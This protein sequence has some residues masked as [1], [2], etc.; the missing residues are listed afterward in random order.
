MGQCYAPAVPSQPIPHP[1]HWRWRTQLLSQRRYRWPRLLTA[2]P[3]RQLPPP[4]PCPFPLSRASFLL[5][6]WWSPGRGSFRRPSRL[7]QARAS[8]LRHQTWNLSLYCHLRHHL[9]KPE[10]TSREKAFISTTR[11]RGSLRWSLRSSKVWR[12]GRD[13]NSRG[14]QSPFGFQD[15]RNRPL[16]HLSKCRDQSALIRGVR[17]LAKGK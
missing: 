11:A 4:P 10:P 9:R 2:S 12:R 3:L 16:C 13:S 7:N 5:L 8:F 17:C 15:R 6:P 1:I 14:P